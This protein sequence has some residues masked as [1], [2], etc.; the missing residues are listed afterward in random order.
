MRWLRL[1][2]PAI[3]VAGFAI[4]GRLLAR[5]YPRSFD[6]IVQCDRGHRYR[7]IWV[8]GGSLKAVRW[9]DQRLQWCPVGRHWGWTRRLDASRLSAG[10]LEAGNAIHDLAIV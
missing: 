8:P 3:V 6:P 10:E 5:W 1:L 4:V 7:S 2:L 9:F